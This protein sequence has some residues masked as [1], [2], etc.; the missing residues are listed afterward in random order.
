V[1]QDAQKARLAQNEDLFR[2]VNERIDELAANHGDD[3]HVYEFFCECSDVACLER[4][5][6]SLSEYAHVREDP[7]RFVVVKGHVLEEIE[8]VIEP[9]E[10]HVLIEKDGVAGDVAIK[11]DVDVDH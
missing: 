8:H 11:L 1:V 6:L 10:D 4:V 3:S 5:R 2:Q 7:T 9:A